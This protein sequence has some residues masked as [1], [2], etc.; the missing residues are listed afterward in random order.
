MCCHVFCILCCDQLFSWSGWIYDLNWLKTDSFHLVG[1]GELPWGLRIPCGLRQCPGRRRPLDAS[2]RPSS[3]FL[4]WAWPNTPQTK[5]A[6]SEPP[7]FHEHPR[8]PHL[9]DTKMAFSGSLL[10][11]TGFGGLA[12]VGSDCNVLQSCSQPLNAIMQTM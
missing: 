1:R 2:D 7:L 5:A 3:R 6:S 4:V 11:K 8:S 12:I 9:R 10:Y